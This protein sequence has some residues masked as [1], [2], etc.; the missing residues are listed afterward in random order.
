M[1]TSPPTPPPTSPNHSSTTYPTPPSSKLKPTSMT[2]ITHRLRWQCADPTKKSSITQ[3]VKN[4]KV[5]PSMW[6]FKIKC[7]PNSTVKKF[8]A[9][10]CICGNKQTEGVDYFETWAPI[11]QWSTIRT[12]LTLTIKLKWVSTHCDITTAFIH[13]TL[14]STEKVFVLQPCGFT[15]TSRHVLRLTK[16]LYGL[17]Q[18]P[19]HFF[20]YLTTRLKHRGLTQSNLDPCL[21]LLRQDLLIIVYID[22]LLVY[23]PTHVII[24]DFISQ[25]QAKNIALCCKGTTEGYLGVD[26][27]TTNNSIILTQ[28]GLTKSIISALG[29]DDKYSASCATPA[30]GAPLPKDDSGNSASR[31]INYASIVGMMLY[32]CGHS[33]PD[34]SFAVH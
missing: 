6:T 2:M 26:L 5:L 15:G 8:K 18:A 16:S 12:I 3:C 23:A 24:N 28:V 11:V 34:I 27:H 1:A 33:R 20:A 4:F 31:M 10:F 30:K 25:M 13:T 9:W 29:L 17:C 22:D 21:F 19:R 14:P 32:L 7:Y